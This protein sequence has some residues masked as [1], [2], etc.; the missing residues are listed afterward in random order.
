M[1]AVLFLDINFYSM[2]TVQVKIIIGSTRENR[3]ADSAGAWIADELSKQEGVHTEVLDLRDYPMPFFD[4]PVSASRKSE[5]FAHEAVARFTQ[6]IAEADAYVLVTPEYNRSTSGVLKNAL[7]WV[8]Q[9]W[10]EKPVTFVSYGAVGGA[11]AV[12][13]LRLMAIELQ[14]APIRE[15]IHFAASDYF[16]VAMGG[17]PKEELFAKYAQ[18]AE[19]AIT[20]LLRWTRGLKK[21][22]E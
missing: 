13:Q 16:P 12:E 1:C 6:K 7:D 8:Y 4:S 22:R 10:H 3:F 21:M 11:R 5:P 2:D 19:S 20:Q 17:A 14:M 18:S 9:E 15:A